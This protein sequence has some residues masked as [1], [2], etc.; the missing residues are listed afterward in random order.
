MLS[1]RWTRAL[2]ISI[3]AFG[4]ALL[5]GVLKIFDLEVQTNLF[6]TGITPGM[7][8]GV[9]LLLVSYGIFKNRI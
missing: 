9:A 6:S 2:G 8:I 3:T 7:V 4:G 1:T 5:L